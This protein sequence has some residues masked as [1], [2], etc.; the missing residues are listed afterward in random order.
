MTQL[1]PLGLIK[2]LGHVSAMMVFPILGGSVIGLVLDRN[3]GSSPLY[4][5]IGFA[6]GNLIAIT[7]IWLYIRWH[8]RRGFRRTGPDHGD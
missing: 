1:T 4:V 5:L 3:L 2:I 8:T 7:A 6:A